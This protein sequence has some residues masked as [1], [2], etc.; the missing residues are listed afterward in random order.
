MVYFKA[1]WY[2]FAVNLVYFPHFGML[3]P[4]KSGN[5]AAEMP[6]QPGTESRSCCSLN[7][8]LKCQAGITALAR[9]NDPQARRQL[10][11]V[12]RKTKVWRKKFQQKRN[13]N[14]DVCSA[15]RRQFQDMFIP[16]LPEHQPTS[17]TFSI[18]LKLKY[19]AKKF[20]FSLKLCN[21]TPNLC[22]PVGCNQHPASFYL[23][24][25]PFYFS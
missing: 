22:F 21:L 6:P 2:I 9:K 11:T 7:Q 4:E 25:S 16:R 18:S 23:Y 20:P 12:S 8:T 14:F 24:V 13:N 5:P 1:I 19:W 15:H 10:K 17:W 3:Y